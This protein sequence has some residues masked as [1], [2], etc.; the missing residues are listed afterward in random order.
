MKIF[1]VIVVVV[2][3]IACLSAK[4]VGS[5][6]LAFLNFII[7]VCVFHSLTKDWGKL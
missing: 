3:I 6:G 1:G 4:S 7:A 2:S 5:Y